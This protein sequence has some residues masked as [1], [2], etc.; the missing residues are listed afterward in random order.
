VSIASAERDGGRLRPPVF[1]T[2]PVVASI[3]AIQIPNSYRVVL[4]EADG[5]KETAVFTV[6]RGWVGTT[7]NL[8]VVNTDWDIFWKWPGDAE[9]QQSITRQVLE[10]HQS[11][12]N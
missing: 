3:A 1:G 10:F 11:R 6:R 4:R 5:H 9:S 8:V 2:L 12:G 7:D